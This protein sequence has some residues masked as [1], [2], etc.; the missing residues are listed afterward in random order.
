MDGTACVVGIGRV[1]IDRSTAATAF[2]SAVAFPDAS[3]FSLPDA[4]VVSAAFSSVVAFPDASAFP[5]PDASVVST[6]SPGSAPG[7]F[8]PAGAG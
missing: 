3:V 6:A 7:R 2:S 5:L 8:S 1:R 4:S